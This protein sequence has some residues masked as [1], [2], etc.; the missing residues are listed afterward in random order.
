M[1]ILARKHWEIFL[2]LITLITFVDLTIDYIFSCFGFSIFSPITSSVNLLLKIPLFLFYPY[3]VGK[4][5][6]DLLKNQTKFKSTSTQSVISLIG[7]LI[8]INILAY[9]YIEY[10]MSNS[11][12]SI[13]LII[14]MLVINFSLLFK[15]SS[16]GPRPM[17]SIELQRTA[18]FW[19]YGEETFQFLFW[20]IG[21]WWTQP[22][23]NK[24][25]NKEIRIIE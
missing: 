1:K 21:I 11:E 20:P 19:E 12:P 5:L 8:L 17:K 7:I 6:N 14:I 25:I 22:K 24:L 3:R 4:E 2:V 23:I 15:I 10:L 16:F 9:V 13:L 18:G